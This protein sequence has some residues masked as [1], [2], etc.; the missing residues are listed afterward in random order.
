MAKEPF[1]TPALC[2][3]RIS[4]LTWALSKSFSPFAAVGAA[5]L[6]GNGTLLVSWFTN[7]S[8]R[9][10]PRV[11]TE[12]PSGIDSK[13]KPLGSLSPTVRSFV[14]PTPLMTGV[15]ID[16]CVVLNPAF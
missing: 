1:R 14:T 4:W 11:L 7:R 8:T 10:C 3:L 2:R 9:P 6:Y 13:R 5:W 15:S 12:M 16:G